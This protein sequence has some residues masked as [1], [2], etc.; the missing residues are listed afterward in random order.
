MR[1]SHS[2]AA[3]YADETEQ[4]AAAIAAEES[5]EAE[6]DRLILVANRLPVTAKREPDGT[7]NLQATSPSPLP[8]PPA[9]LPP[10][11]QPPSPPF[12]HLSRP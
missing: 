3:L 9:A 11:Q 5:L 4:M 12:I 1:R 2:N 10:K 6:R 8:P 7:W